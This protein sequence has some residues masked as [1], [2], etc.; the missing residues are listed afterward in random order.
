MNFSFGIF[1][2]D[3][4]V[5]PFWFFK[6][7]FEKEAF[8]IVLT[9]EEVKDFLNWVSEPKIFVSGIKGIFTLKEVF[10]LFVDFPEGF[11]NVNWE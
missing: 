10:S 3:L 6:I 7:F 11:L 9:L 5:F 1:W 8:L 4:G 2:G